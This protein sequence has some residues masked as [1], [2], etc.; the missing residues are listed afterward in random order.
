MRELRSPRGITQV[1]YTHDGRALLA[2]DTGGWVHWWDLAT[3]TRRELFQMPG[4]SRSDV[5]A[6][7]VS[8]DARL[9]AAGNRDAAALWDDQVRALI[10]PSGA[11]Y[12]AGYLRLSPE[13]R[14]LLFRSS[15]AGLC[16]WDVA[17][18]QVGHSLEHLPGHN[19]AAFAPD[20]RA[21]AVAE[22]PS[23]GV[24]DVRTGAKITEFRQA[25]NIGALAFSS[26]GEVLAA[27]GCHTAQLWDI[28]TG[29]CRTTIR[30]KRGGLRRVAFHPGGTMLATTGDRR[31]VTLWDTRTGSE[32]GRYNWQ[33]GK[34]SSVAFAPD[35]MTAA[36]GG[37]NRR[38]VIWDVEDVPA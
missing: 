33:I 38:L 24:C 18:R 34:I 7:T 1:A 20:G 28:T 15:E 30:T 37:S 2:G 4:Q 32:V 13:G 29:Q 8:R 35:G 36:A 19:A 10:P 22:G 9:V 12:W 6:L 26:T 16:L 3:G 25:E 5:L 31:D 23:L 14:F 17:Q 27:V 21:L 11:C